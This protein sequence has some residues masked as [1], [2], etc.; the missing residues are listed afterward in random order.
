MYDSYMY[1]WYEGSYY[2]ITT[3]TTTPVCVRVHI[4]SNFL[5]INLFISFYTLAYTLIYFYSLYYL[6]TLH[7]TVY[8]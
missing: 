4:K 1:V 6:Y 2:Y 7:T 3:G 8:A 5:N